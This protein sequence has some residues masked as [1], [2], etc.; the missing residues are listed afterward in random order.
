MSPVNNDPSITFPDG[1]VGFAGPQRF[2]LVQWG[3]D[4]SPFSLLRAVDD[5]ALAFVV[6]PPA[7]FFPDYEPEIDDDTAAVV[8]L[9]SADD[10]LVLV[11]VTVP[12]QVQ[13]ATANLLGP[14]VINTVTLHG[15][16]AV[17]NPDRWPSRRLL[18]EPAVTAA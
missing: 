1:L 6:V 8:G 11:I 4:D 7:V 13:D 12:D 5:E 17:L 18:V 10:A 14:L 16:Q 3:G 2:V 15:V 9:Q